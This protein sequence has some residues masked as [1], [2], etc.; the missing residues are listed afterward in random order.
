MSE[1]KRNYRIEGENKVAF[2]EER[3]EIITI[4]VAVR[5]D[6]VGQYAVYV[7]PEDWPDLQLLR[8]GMK[9]H[10]TVGPTMVHIL[11]DMNLI[12]PG[13]LSKEYRL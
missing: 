8:D 4:K 2:T 7:A 11:Q 3:T 12:E 5:G 9:L 10:S 6:A 1:L 13:F